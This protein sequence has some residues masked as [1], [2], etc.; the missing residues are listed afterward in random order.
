VLGEQ[1]W[2]EPA[3]GG[4]DDTEQLKARITTLEQQVIDLELQFQDQGDDLTAAR[5]ANPELMAQLNRPNAPPREPVLL[6]L[7]YH[8]H[9]GG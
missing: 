7:A 6:R 5:A 4:P 9:Q 2:N 1:V 3:L 8:S